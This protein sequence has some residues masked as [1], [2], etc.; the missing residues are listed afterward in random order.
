[1]TAEKNI[2][3]PNRRAVANR[4]AVISAWDMSEPVG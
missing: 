1:M 2:I 4:P 3:E